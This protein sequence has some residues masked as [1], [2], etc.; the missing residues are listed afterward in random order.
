MISEEHKAI[1]RRAWAAYDK[2]D[3]V[4]FA[5]CVTPDWR[6]HNG[7]GHVSTLDDMRGLMEAQRRAFP[8]KRTQ[9]V[10]ELVEGDLLAHRTITTAT[11]TGRYFD[12]DPTGR[13]LL[14]HEIN[15]HRIVGARIAETWIAVSQPGGF[16]KQL[17][18]RDRPSE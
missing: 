16:Y 6:E 2:G 1:G 3:A 9:I 7:E 14:L 18:G 13:T 17:S 12:L 4:A 11:H 5:A 15:I 10:Q 8:D